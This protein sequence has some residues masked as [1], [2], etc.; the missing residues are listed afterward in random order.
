MSRWIRAHVQMDTR[1]YPYGYAL[2]SKFIQGGLKNFITINF[3][4]HHKLSPFMTQSKRPKN[5]QKVIDLEEEAEELL[6]EEEEVPQAPNEASKK[7]IEHNMPFT[8]SRSAEAVKSSK[9]GPYAQQIPQPVQQQAQFGF[10]YPNLP[11]YPNQYSMFSAP[12]QYQQ[13]HAAMHPT[14]PGSHHGM[15]TTFSSNLAPNMA[16]SHAENQRNLQAYAAQQIENYARTRLSELGFNPKHIDIKI[17]PQDLN[18][19]LKTTIT[20]A[21]K[22]PLMT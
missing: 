16:P 6:E 11:Q 5:Q 2:M 19:D 10:Q 4:M 15:Q 21:I 13:Y 9:R 22:Q 7:P 1:S 8:R 3:S 20:I 17:K 18:R 14:L 12:Q